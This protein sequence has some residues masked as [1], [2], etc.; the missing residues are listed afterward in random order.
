MQR[1]FLKEPYEPKEYYEIKDEN[2]HHIVRVMRMSVGE[3]NFLV[4]NDGIAIL[5]EIITISEESVELKEISKESMEKEM[6][7]QVTVAC[8]FPKGDKLEWIVQKGTEL[9]AHQ[10]IGFP[11]KTSVVK[12]DHKKRENKAKRLQKIA[13]EAAE[14]SHRQIVPQVHL[15]DKEQALIDGFPKYSQVIVAYEESAKQ[16]EKGNFAKVLTAL[17]TGDNVLVIV[18]PEGGFSEAE[19]TDFQNAGAI[20]CGLGPRILRAETAPLY[21]LSAISYQLELVK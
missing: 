14:Q 1:Y 15:F 11:A 2:Y 10:F 6:P 16:G 3:R 21:V 4:F 20:L 12:W 5:A 17:G 13:T 8:G 9:G 19:I 18:G 7:V